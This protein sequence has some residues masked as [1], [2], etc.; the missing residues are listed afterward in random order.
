[1]TKKNTIKNINSE[2]KL[3]KIGSTKSYKDLMNI[4]RNRVTVRKFD[5]KFRVPDEHYELIIDAARHAPSGANAQPWHFIIV[6]DSKIK[7]NISEYFVNE[8]R[9]RAE[10][11]MKFPTPNY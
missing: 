2:V 6:K 3:P 4:V 8:Q 1:M 11:K 7:K 9:L 5:E 10:L